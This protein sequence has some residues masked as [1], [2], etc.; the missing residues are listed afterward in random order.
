MVK[1]EHKKNKKVTMFLG[2]GTSQKQKRTMTLILVNPVRGSG[3]R[4]PHTQTS[5]H[6]AVLGL[7]GR[8]NTMARHTDTF[9]AVALGQSKRS[10]TRMPSSRVPEFQSSRV[11]E[12]LSSK[13]VPEPQSS[14]VPKVQ[15]P[16]FQSSKILSSKSFQSSRVPEFL[17]S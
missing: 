14:R 2:P 16:K 6:F 11:P 17:R 3:T 12:F 15:I 5:V 1:T 8:P 9:I 10:H 4:E 7:R 13:G